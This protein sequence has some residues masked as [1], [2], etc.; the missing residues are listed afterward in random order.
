MTMAKANDLGSRL[1]QARELAGLTQTAAAKA[2]GMRRPSVSEIESGRRRVTTDELYQV[3]E[4][5]GVS[6]DWLATGEGSAELTAKVRTLARALQGLKESDLEQLE[7]VLKM[8][9]GEKKL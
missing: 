4:L 3:A 5:Y 7:Q 8:I 1:R 9:R 2:L 6:A